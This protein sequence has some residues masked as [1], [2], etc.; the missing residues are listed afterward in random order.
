MMYF[1]GHYNHDLEL[2]RQH[3]SCFC[4]RATN[5]VI[6]TEGIPFHD[7]KQFFLYS[8]FVNLYHEV[9][10]LE[11][12]DLLEIWKQ[13]LPEHIDYQCTYNQSLFLWHRF[14]RRKSY[15]GTKLILKGSDYLQEIVIFQ[16]YLK[17]IPSIAKHLDD[18]HQA[19][20]KNESESY[21]KVIHELITQSN[22]LH[23]WKNSKNI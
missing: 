10:D 17:T 2:Y 19:M 11:F 22:Q 5:K 18:I 21:I 14:L 15:R 4:G 23:R 13:H 3:A 6:K 9:I 12:S 7:L 20:L 1:P 16:K 8:F